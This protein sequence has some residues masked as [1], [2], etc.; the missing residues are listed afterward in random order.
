MPPPP[1][2][3]CHPALPSARH[4]TPQ[5]V[6]VLLPH[7]SSHFRLPYIR[8]HRPSS[9]ITSSLSCFF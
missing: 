4:I 9:S 3:L 6:L 1:H 7:P 5:L 8:P 2:P